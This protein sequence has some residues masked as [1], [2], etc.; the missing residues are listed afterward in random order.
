MADVN[1]SAG[2]T[3]AEVRRGDAEIPAAAPGE[4]ADAA[5]TGDRPHRG[6][7]VP[8]R[9]DEAPVDREP[10]AEPTG[11]TRPAEA[12]AVADERPATASRDADTSTEPERS[13]RE[14]PV[15]AAEEEEH[16][17]PPQKGGN[18][19]VGTAW[20]VLAAGLFEVLFFAVNAL[21]ALVFGG[22]GAVL[23]QIQSIA[24]TVLAWLPVL[25]FFLL[26]E[27]TVLLINRGSRI[28]YVLAS[29]IVAVVVYVLTVLLF[30]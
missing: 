10:A 12:V 2:E 17:P 24:A 1:G 7:A 22:A 13:T 14:E 26:F 28:A 25:L 19:L 23:P 5:P 21:V 3:P 30:S 29:L 8:V 16:A 27:L 15:P 20:V 4:G 18:R 9:A 6:T 11:S